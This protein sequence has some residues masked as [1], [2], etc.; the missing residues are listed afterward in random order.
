MGRHIA[1][2]LA[3]RTGALLIAGAR[4]PD[5]ATA[6]KAAVPTNQLLVL[7]LDVARLAATAAFAAAVKQRLGAEERLAGI[8]C[9]A[10]L[11][12]LGASR[13][14]EDGV[15]ESFAA[16]HLG[17]FALVEA[18]MD[19]LAD[20]AV[21]VTIRSGTHNPDNKLAKMFGVR[22]ADFPDATSV[23]LGKTRPGN[24]KLL[25]MDRYA[26]GKLCDILYAYDMASRVPSTRVRFLLRS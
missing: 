18:L 20:G 17:H 14:T 6:L 10:G 15:D 21:V 9:N 23:A 12:F 19:R 16:N 11:Q 24:D 8:I 4:H 25:G 3:R 13:L 5:K 26:T 22:G 1:K 2:R 7:P